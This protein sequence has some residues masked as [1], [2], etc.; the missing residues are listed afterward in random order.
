MNKANGV[1]FLRSKR[2]IL[3]D[4]IISGVVEIKG[5]KIS[6]IHSYDFDSPLIK[7]Y[8]NN[9]I[10][11]G[12]V[13]VHT[14]GYGGY[15][16]TGVI[17]EAEVND[18]SMIYLK[19]GVTS[20]LATA[21]YNAI[22]VVSTAMEAGVVGAEILGLH[23]EGPFLNPK[24]SEAA[25]QGTIFPK[26]NLKHLNKILTQG[27]G[28]IKMMTI[29]PD[30]EGSHEVI[31]ELKHQKIIV[32]AG[33]TN[34]NYKELDAIKDKID[35]LTHLGNGM[36][37][38]HHRDMGALGYGINTNILTE[39]I[40][41]GRHI[42]KPMLEIIFKVKSINEIILISDT[43]AL[44]GCKAGHYKTVSDD[45]FINSEGVIVN[46]KGFMSGSS[47]SLLS[48]LNYLYNNYDFKI[49]ELFKM[50]SLNPSKLLGID[51]DYGSIAI[52][53]FADIIV[54]DDNFKTIDVY[55]KGKIAYNNEKEILTENPKL[56]DLLKDREFLNF[57]ST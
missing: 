40:A 46:S 24:K 26:P 28:K 1:L 30:L 37:G 17:N 15:S 4:K 34:V 13:D 3:N 57:Y 2:I 52:G 21:S 38:I 53:K 20:M 33:H 18:L 19:E 31:N 43:V 6:T 8:G 54:L 32:A 48:N 36:T 35:I 49:N 27:K 41:D 12:L 44:G 11:P 7:D 56:K 47:F 50:A 25:P 16:Y 22:E 29:A 5:D 45:Y 14:H 42:T 10:A 9:I 39:L 23:I 55:K 51:S